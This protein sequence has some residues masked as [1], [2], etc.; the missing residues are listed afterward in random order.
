M[1]SNTPFPTGA[2]VGITVSVAIIITASVVGLLWLR[3]HPPTVHAI[4]GVELPAS[5]HPV[6]GYTYVPR[7]PP[8]AVQR[9]PLRSLSVARMPQPPA[10]P[11]PH[12]VVH[13]FPFRDP[14]YELKDLR[15]DDSSAE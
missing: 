14:V 7:Q 12:T 15:A 8:P 1:V 5:Y 9:T 6:A 4:R 3:C 2:I 10:P 13:L 11:K